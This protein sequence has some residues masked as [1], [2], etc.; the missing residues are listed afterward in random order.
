MYMCSGW[1]ASHHVLQHRL[2][3]PAHL[4]LPLGRVGLH[5]GATVPVVGHLVRHTL[6]HSPGS[7]STGALLAHTDA[8]MFIPCAVIT[9]H[10]CTHYLHPLGMHNGTRCLSYPLRP[11]PTLCRRKAPDTRGTVCAQV[12]YPVLGGHGD[13]GDLGHCLQCDG[14]VAR[15]CGQH[16]ACVVDVQALHLPFAKGI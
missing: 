13:A 1:L 7:H 8:A 5:V 16:R 2:L 12:T 3:A 14:A 11:A 6:D 4:L 10:S 9:L 15:P